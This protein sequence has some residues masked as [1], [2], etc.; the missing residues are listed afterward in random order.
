MP[1]LPSFGQIEIDIKLVKFDY[2]KMTKYEQKVWL[3]ITIQLCFVL[4]PLVCKWSKF[5]CSLEVFKNMWSCISRFLC[6]WFSFC[7]RRDCLPSNC[8][9]TWCRR[10]LAWW[11][12]CRW[13]LAWCNNSIIPLT[14]CIRYRCRLACT[15]P[16]PL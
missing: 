13:R 11:Y 1:F 5:I 16:L 7:S 8:M 10:M 9:R 3:L 2:I 14:W 4:S 12:C 15:I 6:Y